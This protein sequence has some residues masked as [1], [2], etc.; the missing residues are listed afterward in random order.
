MKI[1]SSAGLAA[2]LVATALLPAAAAATGPATVKLRVEGAQRTIY[3]GTLTTDARSITMGPGPTF[4]N[5]Y[6]GGTHVC[7]GLNGGNQNGYSGTGGTP[8]TALDDAA[9]LGA[10]AW[11][12]FYDSGFDDFFPVT[13]G[14][15]G[16]IAGPYWETRTNAVPNAFGGCQ[17]ELSNG[18]EVLFAI[19]GYGKPG[20]KLSGPAGASPGKP[21]TVS[22][23]DAATSAPVAGADAGG[24]LTGADG[25]V[26]L[27]FDTPGLVHLKAAKAGTVRSNALDVCVTTGSDGACGIRAAQPSAPDITAPIATIA[28]IRNGQRFSRKRAPRELHGSVSEDPSGLL[29]VKIR[30]TRKLGRTCWYFSGSKERFLKRRCGKKYAFKV[31][32]RPRWS[33]LLPS[34]LPRGRYV[35]ETYAIDN[36]FN[37]GATQRVAFR[38][39]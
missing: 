6:P 28:G 20:L 31:G 18:N 11:Y 23:T 3:E 1:R 39:R 25:R 8:H 21:F 19:D 24:L 7:N 22:V 34:R 5:P 2:G 30:L 9:R 27:R 26:A 33:Y 12:G 14:G 4:G 16:A 17:I 35:L 29:A 10:F 15:E 32:D 13:I 38:V 36:A 37:H